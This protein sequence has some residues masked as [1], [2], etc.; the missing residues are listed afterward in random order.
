[1]TL[2]VKV[3]S[4]LVFVAA[5]STGGYYLLSSGNDR[6]FVIKDKSSFNALYTEEMFGNDYSQYMVDPDRYENKKWWEESFKK[7]KSA[8]S[9]TTLSNEFQVQNITLAYSDDEST[10]LIKSLNKACKA[11]LLSNQTEIDKKANYEDNIWY[12]CSVINTR[13]KFSSKDNYTSKVGGLEIYKNKTVSVKTE[14]DKYNSSFWEVR[15]KE[16]F[17]E[18]NSGYS[19]SMASKDSIFSELYKKKLNRGEEDTIKKTCEKVYEA[20]SLDLEDPKMK[21]SDVALFCFLIPEVRK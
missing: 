5:A 13:R 11:A 19:G 10:T 9:S 18:I 1:M 12:F 4:A 7:F 8:S 14:N 6:V 17:D 20:D 3:A 15:N 16:F 2:F 21:D